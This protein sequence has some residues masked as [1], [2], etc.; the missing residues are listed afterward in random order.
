MNSLRTKTVIL[1]VLLALTWLSLYRLNQKIKNYQ[2]LE[3]PFGETVT[4]SVDDDPAKGLLTAPVTM[5][6]FSDFECQYC[7]KFFEETLPL[8]E[9][10][11]IETGKLRFVYRDLPLVSNEPAATSEARA[12]NCAREQ[13]GDET[14]F[15]YH[16]R[17]FETTK[18][19]GSGLNIDQLKDLAEDIGINVEE[20]AS[21][22][23]SRRYVD[24][25]R[26]DY[27]EA[28]RIGAFSTPTFVIGRTQEGGAVQGVVVGGAADISLFQAIIDS[29]L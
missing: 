17:I 19:G 14:Y 27:A 20:F 22:Y 18:S 23:K 28:S 1:V 12:A 6:E 25:V 8:L 15:R 9:E 24:E 2:P 16:D 21:C 5:V 3:S 29:L 13:G 26:A 11:Y 10:Q 7:K 4:T